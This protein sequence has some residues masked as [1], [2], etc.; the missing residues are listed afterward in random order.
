MYE[1]KKYSFSYLGYSIIKISKYV[2]ENSNHQCL[3]QEQNNV[4]N[5]L[6]I[7]KFCNVVD[8]MKSSI[9][10]FYVGTVL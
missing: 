1:K 9:G 8:T 5:T 4:L 7:K 3:A 2:V 10:C 6:H